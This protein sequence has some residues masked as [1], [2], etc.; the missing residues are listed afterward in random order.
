MTTILTFGTIW[1]WIFIAGLTIYLTYKTDEE[2]ADDI[3]ATWIVSIISLAL[4]YFLGNANDFNELGKWI[5]ANPVL[6][7][8]TLVA[9]LLIGVV[10]S[11]FKW[12]FYVKSLKRKHIKSSE[13]KFYAP[14]VEVEYN[15]TR[16][17]GWM[18]YWPLSSVWTIIN[19]PIKR[20]F[21]EILEKT[22]GLYDKIAMR[23]LSDLPE[24][25]KQK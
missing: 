25:N 5:L 9:Y 19:D 17:L 14:K 2:D 21:T 11:L 12:T 4:L 24:N 13:S 3:S 8:L 16:I 23:I 18:M 22:T 10:W 1:F 6:S 20:V 7:I 15:R